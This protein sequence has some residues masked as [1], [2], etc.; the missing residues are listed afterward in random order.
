MSQRSDNQSRYKSTTG[1]PVTVSIFDPALVDYFWNY[2]NKWFALA[3]LRST[4]WSNSH[5]TR[6][7]V[8]LPTRP[9]FASIMTCADG[10]CL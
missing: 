5:P 10:T 3:Q 4:Q 2:Q 1:Q 8:A 6:G 7:R 9:L